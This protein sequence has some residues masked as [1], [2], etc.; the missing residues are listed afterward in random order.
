MTNGQ[1]FLTKD[2]KTFSTKDEWASFLTKDEK[3]FLTK[4]E[5]ASILT[6]DEKTFSTKDEWTS[7][8]DER[9]KNEGF[10]SSTNHTILESYI[11]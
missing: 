3:T 4:D 7:I 2:E 8:F 6:K 9:R 1:V 11:N 5:W 10:E